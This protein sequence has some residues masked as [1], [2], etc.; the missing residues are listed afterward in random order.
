MNCRN[1]GAENEADVRYCIECGTPLALRCPECGAEH[2]DG[3]RFC[4]ACGSALKGSSTPLPPAGVAAAA[5]APGDGVGGTSASTAEMRH[6][7]VLFVD[8]V[9]F[10]AL[11]ES[12]DAE[13]VRELLGRYFESSADDHRPLRRDRGEVHRRCGDGGVGRPVASEDDAE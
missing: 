8:L 5:T 2:R 11:S 6:V 7:S 3:Q 10:T 1:C 9:G 4:G 12:R 13:D